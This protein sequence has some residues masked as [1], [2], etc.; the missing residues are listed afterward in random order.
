MASFTSRVNKSFFVETLLEIHAE[1]TVISI[2]LNLKEIIFSNFQI[3][4]LKLSNIAEFSVFS[5]F[6]LFFHYLYCKVTRTNTR[7][8]FLRRFINFKKP[9]LSDIISL[10]LL[11]KIFTQ[12]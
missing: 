4:I 12:S 1:Q 3:I 11:R 5:Y 8:L 10:I 6:F 2:N 9:F 7:F